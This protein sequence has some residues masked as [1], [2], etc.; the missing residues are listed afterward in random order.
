MKNRTYWLIIAALCLVIG[1]GGGALLHRGTQQE[2][3]PDFTVEDRSGEKV[4]L[5]SLRGSPVIVN[6][7][8]SW[9]GPCQAEMPEFEE[10]Y[11][12]YGDDIVFMMVNLTDGRSDTRESADAVIAEGGYTFPVYYDTTGEA[13]NAY[14]INAIPV[15]LFIDTH[16]KL[17]YQKTGMMDAAELQSWIDTL[18]N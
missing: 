16:G 11:K 1:L 2:Q 14:G 8:A 3:A 9:C 5:R 4:S 12:Q 17:L 13:A 15:T 10:A 7:W 18:L 6:F